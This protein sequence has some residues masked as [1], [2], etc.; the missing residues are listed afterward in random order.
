MTIATTTKSASQALTTVP[1]N[2]LLLHS[3]LLHRHLH[4]LLLPH[5]L[6]SL[7]PRLPLLRRG[8]VQPLCAGNGSIAYARF[9]ESGLAAVACNNADVS[10]TLSLPLACAGVPD[11][12]AVARVFLTDDAGFSETRELTGVVRDGRLALPMA[13]RSA[14]VLVPAE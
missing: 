14:V 12:T 4:R 7:P 3:L 8:S 2:L 1:W 5:R 10:Q 13:P 11:G 6:L 9:D